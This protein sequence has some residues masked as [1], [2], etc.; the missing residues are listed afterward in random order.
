MTTTTNPLFHHSI[1][2]ALDNG[3][4]LER[5]IARLLPV[6]LATLLVLDEVARDPGITAR[7]LAQALDLSEQ[8]LSGVVARMERDGLLSRETE[9]TKTGRV[10]HITLTQPG[11]DLLAECRRKLQD[12]GL[13]P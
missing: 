7:P 12:G 3:R 10:A 13:A 4:K 2:S 6:Q 11:L 5:D 8:T 9:T 1:R